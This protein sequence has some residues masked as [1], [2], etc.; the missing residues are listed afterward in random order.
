MA[1]LDDYTALITSEHQP[2]PRFMA[3]V[4][5]LAAPAVDQ[6][7]VLEGIPGL[8]DLDVAVGDQLDTVAE[9][10]GTN[11]RVKTPLTGVYF[12]F[13]LDG[14]GF[15]QGVWKGPFDPDTGLTLLDDDTFRMV[16][17]AQIAAN[18]WDGTPDGA[19]AILELLAPVGSLVFI[20]DNQ[21]MSMTIGVAG[22][23]PSALF[24]A[25]LNNGLLSIKPEAVR[26]NYVI[27]TINGAPLF[28]FDCD[29]AYCAGFNA[30]T[31]GAPTIIAQDLLDYTFVL[32]VSLLG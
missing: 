18:H 11:R 5:A 30:G 20:Q 27:T 1:E 26:V 17:R 19:A 6:I 12:S 3:V 31:W 24:I 2:R 14:L 13:D 9:W 23:Q 16:I 15:D 8:F 32:D 29:N 7:N 25:L 28:G 21:D 4:A 22:K 10:V